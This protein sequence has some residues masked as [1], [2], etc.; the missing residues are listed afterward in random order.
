ML[1]PKKKISKRELKQDALVTTYAELTSFYETHK[2]NISIGITAL[3]VVIIAAVV[4]F[5]NRSDNNEMAMTQLGSVYAIYDAGQYQLAIDGIPERNIRGLRS[6]VENYGSSNAGNI[7]RFYLAGAYYQL[8]NYDEALKF[9][10]DCS[11]A[12]ELMAVSRLAGMADCYEAKGEYLKAAENFEKAASKNSKDVS[13]ADNLN[14]AARNY[15]RAGEKEK[16]LD[17][18]RRLKKNYPSTTYGREA[19]RYIEQLS[20]NA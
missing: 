15:A 18:Y 8:G 16:A 7:A 19:D 14:N 10:E 12:D 3:V 9:F 11:P 13:I 5:K 2:K 20:I 4:Y 17:L 1:R 6:I